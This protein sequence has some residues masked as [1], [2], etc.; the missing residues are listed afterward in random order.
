MGIAGL[1]GGIG[2]F[3]VVLDGPA[4]LDIPDRPVEPAGP[5][6]SATLAI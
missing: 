3:I 5:G 2:I 6:F 1:G 4:A